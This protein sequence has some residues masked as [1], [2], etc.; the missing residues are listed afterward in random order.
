MGPQDPDPGNRAASGISTLQVGGFKAVLFWFSL[1]ITEVIIFGM[2]SYIHYICSNTKA[3]RLWYSS[4]YSHD[5]KDRETAHKRYR[6]YPSAETHAFYISARNLA[7][8]ILQLTK[9]SFIYRKCQYLSNSTS[10]HYFRHKASN[11]SNNFTFSYFPPLLQPDGSTAVSSFSKAELFDQ[12]FATHSTLDDTGH[13]PPTPPPSDYFIPKTKTLHYDVFSA[14]SGHDSWK[15]YG[16]YRVPPI[17]LKNWGRS[18]TWSNFSACLSTSTYPSCWKLTFNLSL[19][20]V[21]A[22]IFQTTAV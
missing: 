10:C 1:G 8:S 5:V 9:N 13:I 12:T 3:E 14:L 15:A 11:I 6:S 17:V 21:T 7:K 4:S 22:P 2:E 18:P 19:K 16:Y 20:T